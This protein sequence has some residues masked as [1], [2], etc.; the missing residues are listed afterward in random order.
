[1]NKIML[2]LKYYALVATYRSVDK[3]MQVKKKNLKQLANLIY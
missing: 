2:C 3:S 1:M